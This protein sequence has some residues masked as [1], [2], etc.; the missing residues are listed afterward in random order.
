MTP[1][2]V[3]GKSK[4]EQIV[5]KWNDDEKLLSELEELD[6]ERAEFI[7]GYYEERLISPEQAI[8]MARSLKAIL[9][10]IRRRGIQKQREDL[11]RG[12]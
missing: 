3:P 10:R 7:Y 6:P 1:D 11:Q 9:Q 4:L 8:S 12:F 2:Q 5:K